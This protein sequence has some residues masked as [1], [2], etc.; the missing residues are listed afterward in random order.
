MQL[1]EALGLMALSSPP[2]ACLQESAVR[3][4][5]P[6]SAR[7]PRRPPPPA[8]RAGR[9]GRSNTAFHRQD[10]VPLTFHKKIFIQISEYQLTIVTISLENF[11]DNYSATLPSSVSTLAFNILSNLLLGAMVHFCADF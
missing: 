7:A 9:G 4:A 8:P 6:A 10:F 3:V 1:S 5:R 11:I 2:A